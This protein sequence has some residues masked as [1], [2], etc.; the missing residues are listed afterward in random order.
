M[1]IQF[2]E[3]AEQA[4]LI[5]KMASKNPSEAR[6]AQEAF[7]AFMA[8]KLGQVLDQIDTTR[9]VYRDQTFNLAAGVPPTIPVDPFLGFGEKE[10][11]VW[12][13]SVAG[14]LATNHVYKEIEEILV[15]T[16]RLDS[17]ISWSKQYAANVRMDLIAKY[18]A[19]L[20]QTILLKTNRQAWIPLLSALATAE[21]KSL[22]NVVRAATAGVFHFGDLNAMRTRIRRMNASWAN[23]TPTVDTGKLTDI[24]M[25]PEI[26]EQLRGM[27]YNPINTKG[28]NN[29]A[30][31]QY[32][33]VVTLPDEQRAALLA[34]GDVESFMGVNIIELNELGK[35]QRYNDLFDTVAGSTTFDKVAGSAAA[36]FTSSTE[37]LI[38]GLDL[39]KDF[40]FRVIEQDPETKSTFTMVSDD[41]FLARS[42]KV[43]QYGYITEGR[44]IVNTYPMVGWI[45]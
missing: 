30:G 27:G 15:Q 36:T 33:G 37:E 13:Q 35:S 18:I 22:K 20:L 2:K 41:Q 29:V 39:T 28:A 43:G 10:L 19:M 9:L 21:N 4:E 45:V 42:E 34:G 26:K 40:A 31:T 16:Y 23:G 8:I 32:S 6:Q 11:T 24:V 12:S 3:T 17:A 44:V 5:K 14:G 7:A 25:S 38:I 1:R